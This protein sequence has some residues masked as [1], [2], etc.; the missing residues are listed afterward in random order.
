MSYLEFDKSRL[1]NLEYSLNKEVLRS[2]RAGSYGSTTII[3][4]NTRKYHGLLVCPLEQ[5]DGEKH[6]LL[7]TLDETVVQHGSEFNLGIHKYP[8]DQYFPKGH[9]YVRDFE[10]DLVAKTTYRVG[11]VILTRESLLV[12]KEEQVL[13]KYTLVDAHSPTLLRLRPFLAFRNSHTLTRANMY[14]STRVEP[15]INGNKIRVYAGYPYLHMQFSKEPEF[16]AIPDWYYNIEYIEEMKRGYDFQEDLL[17]PGYFEL[18]IKKGET[19]IFSAAIKEADPKG[20]KR[21]FENE[22]KS[23]LTRDSF[24]HCLLNASQQFIV[25]RDKK[26]EIIAGYPWFG[27]W[28]RD[29][30]I[31]LPGLTLIPGDIKT[32]RAVVDTQ[33]AKMKGG[34]FPN[35]GSDAEPAF[36]SVDAP[37]WFFWS[38]QQFAIR[39]DAHAEVWSKY[40][41]AMK[42]VLSAYREGAQFNI[43]MHDNKLIYAGEPG[44]ALTWMD[45]VIHGKPVTA[46]IGYPVEINALWYNAVMFALELARLAKDSKFIS[47]WKD[48]PEK[49]RESFL[50]TF[51]DPER[52]YCA[53]VVNNDVKDFAVRPNMVLAS[54]LPYTPLEPEMI[55]KILDL[56]RRELLTPRGLRTLSPNDAMYE[57]IY[58]GSQEQRDNAYHQGTVWPWLLQFYA[59]S[60][61][62]IH[63]NSS[64]S[65]LKEIFEGFE[66]VLTEYGVGTIG[67]IFDG[68][69]PFTPR[70]AVSQAWSVASLLIIDDLIKNLSTPSAVQIKN[71]N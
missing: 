28:G 50:Q 51:W 15:S 30:F 45:A 22:L 52:G 62:R 27:S 25:R 40:G 19:I 60:W 14:A 33:I 2:N 70:G 6:V 64:L 9:K 13:I 3:G 47:Q 61:T 57:G 1:I 41:K 54:A 68:D 20:F 21:K 38:L 71:E 56:T 10:V 66:Q 32:F 12:E 4:C 53:D 5:L 7:S 24:Y 39:C 58:E 29:T 67:E 48:L 44:K 55:K 26:T 43:R 49:I 65:H 63:K 46:R 17:V 37:L 11:G 36:N 59:I 69:P 8:G 31:S 16:V 42:A 34:L 35:M 18:P 23:R